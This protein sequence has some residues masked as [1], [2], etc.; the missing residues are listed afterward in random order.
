MGKVLKIDYVTN[1][2]GN[3]YLEWKGGDLILLQSQVGTGKTHFIITTLVPQLKEGEKLLYLCNRKKLNKDIKYDLLRYLNE[4]L[5]KNKLEEENL[6][7]REV[8]GNIHVLNYQRLEACLNHQKFDLNSFKFCCLDEIHY[9]NVDSGFNHKTFLSKQA[10]IDAKLENS[11]KILISATM[12]KVV[13]HINSDTY[14]RLYSYNTGRDFSYLNPYY[15]NNINDIIQLII[16]DDTDNKWLVFVTSIDKGNY[17][18]NKLL[19]NDIEA[20]FTHRDTRKDYIINEQFKEKVYIC[21]KHI[22]NGVS[23]VDE[24]LKNLVIM[25]YD[26]T[27]FLQEIGRCRVN[28]KDAREIDL[29][30]PT[31]S[32]KNFQK[33]MDLNYDSK[34]ELI[35][36]FNRNTKTFQLKYRNDHSKIPNTLFVLDE[37]NHWQRNEEGI[38][39]LYEDKKFAEK[40]IQNFEEGYRGYK[41]KDYFAYVKEQLNWLQLDKTFDVKRLIKNVPA[42]YELDHLYQCLRVITGKKLFSDE[43]QV[44]SDLILNQLVTVETGVDYRT[45][46]LNHKTL[47]SILRDQLNLPF[48]VSKPKRDRSRKLEDGSPNP[49]RDKTYITINE[50]N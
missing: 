29:Y 35:K 15:F 6:R 48:A 28:I 10:L 50:L 13:P 4:P 5:P 32:K 2:V 7:R 11:I 20:I 43:Q 14:N 16:N 37:N 42:K 49:N 39:K 12:D 34:I 17:I 25:S 46:K 33:K 40:M 44:I 41:G 18:K 24:K 38:K 21:T 30:I 19:D 22:D 3:E 9:I 27:T 45:K 8:F 36:E 31:F 26:A 1:I 23:I 47:E